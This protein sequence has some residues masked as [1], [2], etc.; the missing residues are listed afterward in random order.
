MSKARARCTKSD[1][2]RILKAAAKACVDVRVEI[3][4][5]GNIII[6]TGKLAETMIAKPA[7]LA[8]METQVADQGEWDNIQ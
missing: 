4:P 2:S 6:A 7:K 1:I 5:D 8:E 3:D